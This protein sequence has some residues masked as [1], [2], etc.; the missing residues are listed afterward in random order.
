MQPI[1]AIAG[2]TPDTNRHFWDRYVAH[3]QAQGVKPTVVRRR[4]AV[5]LLLVT[6]MYRR[7]GDR[8]SAREFGVEATPSARNRRMRAGSTGFSPFVTMRT[9][10][11]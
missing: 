8:L 6:T 3:M 2:C 5:A 11:P 1:E 10:P 7:H 4:L 9:Q